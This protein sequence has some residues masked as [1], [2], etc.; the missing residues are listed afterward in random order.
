MKSYIKEVKTLLLITL[1]YQILDNIYLISIGVMR[2]FKQ[3]AFLLK[4]VI[5]SYWL[6]GFPFGFIFSKS[7]GGYAYWY[8]FIACFAVA[9]CLTSYKVYQLVWKNAEIM[10]K[11]K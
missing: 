9:S 10:V 6:V 8:G 7:L 2:A 5:V 3:N 11:S 4:T 1:G